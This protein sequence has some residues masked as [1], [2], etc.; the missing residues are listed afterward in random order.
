[1]FPTAP[2]RVDS[3]SNNCISL[4]RW[5]TRCFRTAWRR[6]CFSS[7]YGVII[8]VLWEYGLCLEWLP[9]VCCWC[10]ST[11]EFR[12]ELLI[13]AHWSI[14]HHPQRSLLEHELYA[15]NK[16]SSKGDRRVAN[17]FFLFE[18]QRVYT[19]QVVDAVGC[20]S[21][22]PNIFSK[23]LLEYLLKNESWCKRSWYM[24]R[25]QST[26]VTTRVNVAWWYSAS[27]IA[28]NFH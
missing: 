6:R 4:K 21:L 7:H 5:A 8:T 19:C 17:A 15:D 25:G 1:M 13:L 16:L 27:G 22:I 18:K 12:V 28:I 11:S 23:S 9:F 26:R 14:D 3:W 20:L 24:E 10:C 2:H